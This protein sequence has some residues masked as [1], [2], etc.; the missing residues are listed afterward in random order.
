MKDAK[1][2]LAY[3]SAHEVTYAQARGHVSACIG[4]QSSLTLKTEFPSSGLEAML[5]TT[6]SSD[7]KPLRATCEDA[8]A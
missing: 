1:F 8:R 2:V 7:N 5:N 4:A 6:S 3:T